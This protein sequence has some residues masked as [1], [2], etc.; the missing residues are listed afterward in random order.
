MT[1][2]AQLAS[3]ADRVVFLRDGRIVDQTSPPP[4]PK[5]LLDVEPMTA[6]ALLERPVDVARAERR[7]PGAAGRHPLGVRLFRGSGASSC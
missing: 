7:R 2:D 1:H 5:S 6:A 4:A 3:W